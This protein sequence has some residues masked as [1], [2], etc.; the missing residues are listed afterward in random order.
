M[1][2]SNPSI[3]PAIEDKQLTKEDTIE[4]LADDN[5]ESETIELEKAPKKAEKTE[6]KADKEDKQEDKD[7]DE[8]KSVEDELEEELKEELETPDE[9]ELE[10]ISPV[11]RKEILAK[12][13]NVFKDFPYLEKAYYFDRQI[14]EILPT[15]EDAK[16]AVEKAEILDGFETD[17]M[18]GSTESLLMQVKENDKEAFAKVVDNYL[19]TLYKVDQDAYFHTIGNITKHTIISMVRDGKENGI[20]ELVDAADT[21]NQYMF[22]T[23]QFSHPTRLSKVEAESDNQKETELAERETEFNKQRF[24]AAKDTII[25]KIDNIVKSTID[26]HIDP[27]ESMTDYVRKNATRE[28]NEKLENIIEGDKRFMSIYDKLWERAANDNYSKESMDKVRDAYLSKAKVLLPVLIK[29][30][31]NEALRGLGK[32]VPD[33]DVKDKKGPLPVG[34]SRSSASSQ[35]SGKSGNER[36]PKRGES[37][38]EFLM[39]D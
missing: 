22:G 38:L 9:T 17:I 8:A 14:T 34:K 7:E 15:I 23:K 16:V 18:G 24:E 26:K 11:R 12:Y 4:F 20:K 25:N 5:A 32:R 2:P 37:S 35:N 36:E 29:N 33:D 6:D 30:A 19:P 13:P 1:S 21:L 39:R 3:E 10:L 28:V 31:R 27:R